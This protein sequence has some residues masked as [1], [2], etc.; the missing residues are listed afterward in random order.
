[1]INA[2][3]HRAKRDNLPFNLEINDIRI[4]EFCPVLGIKLEI[5]KETVGPNSPSLDK[6]IVNKGY[7]KGNVR[8]I[9]HRANWLKNNSNKE[10]LAL[11]YKDSLN[12]Y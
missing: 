7:V 3:R 5:N 8:V 9:S 1:M 6:I 12:N 10:E 2:A 4:P 11:I